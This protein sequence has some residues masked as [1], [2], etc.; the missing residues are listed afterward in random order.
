[1]QEGLHFDIYL[2]YED[3]RTR[4]SSVYLHVHLILHLVLPAAIYPEKKERLQRAK[5]T[6][7]HME[8]T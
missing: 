7:S 4:I 1:M 5:H 8:P 6:L 3:L 2:V